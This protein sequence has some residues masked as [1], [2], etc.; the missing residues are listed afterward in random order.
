[1]TTAL[2]LAGRRDGLTDPLALE[3]GVSHKCLAPVAGSPM[4]T[5][6]AAALAASDGIGE[7]RVAIEDPE[8]LAGVP[9]L[10]R[11]L[12]SGRMMPVA[13]RPNLVDS[14]L[15]AAQGAQ[16]PLFITTADNVLLTP[17][18]VA[19]MLGQCGTPGTDAAVAFARRESV[20]AAHPEGQR[21]FYRFAE[22]SYSNCNSYWLK[23]R[24]ALTAAETF[25]SGGQFV[26]HPMRIVNAFG[27][28]NLVR[29]RLGIGTLAET[30]ARFSRRFG[31]TIAPVILSDG[32]VAIDVDNSR[33]RAVAAELLDARMTVAQAAE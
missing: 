7:I 29:F 11:L 22:G 28:L 5:H 15:A 8:V 24:A 19:D 20:L 9:L 1:M 3:A 30:F 12:D 21:K 32:A 10:R 23:D 4:L 26:K 18:A 16:F 13:A 14:I 33:T 31:M 6:V 25:R 27:F 17:E 2:I